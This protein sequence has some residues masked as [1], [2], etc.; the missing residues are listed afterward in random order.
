MTEVFDATPCA[1]GEG[2]LWHPERGQLF[3]FDIIGKRLYTRGDGVTRHWSFDDQVSA[4][5]WIG[6]D[7]LLIASERA[8]FRF[9]LASG[10][11]T[12]VADLEADNP[13]TRSNDG[14]ADPYGGFWIGTMGKGAERGAGAIWRWYRG[15]LRRLFAPVTVSNAISFTPDG[16]HAC[17]ADSPTRRVMKV[18]L[19]DAG[20]PVGEPE[21]H[22]DLTGLKQVPD[23]AV[24]DAEGVLWLAEW[25]GGR[26]AA[27]GPDGRLLRTV[28]VDAPQTTCPAFGG[29]DLSTLYVTTAREG[30][31]AEALAARPQSGMTFAA[32]PGA[33]GQAEHRVVL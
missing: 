6:R 8:L 14:R 30:L 27:Y 7:A 16:R 28:E 33:R 19:D 24:F 2:P 12:H 23:G 32:T 20:W 13:V 18:A 26:V 17:F 29:A 25:R 22:V 1:L 15:E 9:D 4:A 3:W 10:S 11:R 31:D 21:V 5:G